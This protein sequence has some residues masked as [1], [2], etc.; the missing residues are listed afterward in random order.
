MQFLSN[1][2]II[3]CFVL[4]STNS[5]WAR[6]LKGVT[7]PETITISETNCKLVGLGIRKKLIINV[8]IGALYMAQPAKNARDVISANQIKRIAMHFLYKEVSYEQLVEAW[9]EGFEKNAENAFKTIRDKINTFNS[10]FTESVK[11]GDTVVLTYVPE[12][13]TEVV[14]KNKVKGI[15]EGQ[16]FMEAVFSIWFGPHPPS[17]G[18]KKGMLGE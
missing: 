16:A 3:F 10:F 14:I 12:Q 17:K 9:N 5:G 8:Y 7:F 6:E 2:V 1:V 13:G 18:L 11:K 4:F 15:I